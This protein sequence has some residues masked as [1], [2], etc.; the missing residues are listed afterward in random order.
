MAITE[1]QIEEAQ[2]L[3]HEAAHDTNPKVRLVAG[4]GTGK[5]YAIGERIRWLLAEGVPPD[6]IRAVSFTRAASAKLQE[7]IE[8]YCLEHDQAGYEFVSV[9]TLHSLGL[10]SLRRA[11]ML[12]FPVDPMVLDEFEV[13]VILDAE[14][15]QGTG[16]HPSRCKLIREDFEA[17]SST[18]EY[19]P[20]NYIS[21]DPPISEEERERYQAFHT[22][23]THLYAC[24]L[25]GEIVRQ[26]VDR[27][28]S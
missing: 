19:E 15:S 16:I 8:K 12:P 23:R 28:D 10:K 3:Q 25:P 26:C 21:P 6:Q 22:P 20:V 18:G 5:S 13:G 2:G 1:Q 4:P 24:V 7:K 9:S 11:G 17:F 14:F 27:M